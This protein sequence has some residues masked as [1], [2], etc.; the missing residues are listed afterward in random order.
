[1]KA[2]HL[3]TSICSIAL[4]QLVAGC[5]PSNQAPA[6]GKIVLPATT[7]FSL[8]GDTLELRSQSNPTQLAFGQ[9]QADG[10]FKVESLVDGKVVSGA[11][12][13]KYQARLVISD[14][15]YAHKSQAA[16]A[17]P[18]KFLNFDTSAIVV[19]VPNPSI[20]VNITK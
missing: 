5:G 15:D 19:E 14:D 2:H 4:L 18:K 12:V 7:A 16:K 13:G 8:A 10:S 9:I 3:I 20:E 17:I 11:P 1:M 6:G